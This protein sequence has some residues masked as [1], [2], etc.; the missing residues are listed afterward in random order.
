MVRIRLKRMGTIR[1]PFYRIVVADSRSSRNG[2]YIESI[3]YY[4]PLRETSKEKVNIERAV[5][6]LK[7]GAKP[8]D[9]VMDIFTRTGVIKEF[10]R[11]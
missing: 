7:H 2:A 5:Y 11:K 8:T 9:V 4:N 10:H 3:G 6:W 1:K